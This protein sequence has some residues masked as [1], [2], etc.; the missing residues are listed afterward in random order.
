[1]IGHLDS[2]AGQLL[3]RQQPLLTWW[4]LDRKDGRMHCPA[5]PGSGTVTSVVPAAPTLSWTI[6]GALVTS[7]G[8]TKIRAGRALISVLQ[9]SLRGGGW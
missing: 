5:T 6:G 2:N 3:F 9:G 4:R 1:V 7:L 8:R